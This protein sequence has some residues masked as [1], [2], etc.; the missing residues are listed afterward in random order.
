MEA[1]IK[2]CV[3]NVA[4]G[5]WYPRGQER[6][7]NSLIHHGY[8][9]KILTWCNEFPNDNYDKSSPYNVKAAAFEEAIKLGFTHI[10]WLDCSAWLLKDISPIFDILNSDGYYG[11]KSGYNCAQTCCDKC[12][13]YF[14]VLRDDAEKMLDCST[15]MFGVNITNPIG[16]EFIE[17]FI[18]ACKDGIATTS[19]F[20]DNQ[21]QD[22]R[23][24]FSR[25]EQSIASILYNT[26]GMRL[27]DPNHLSCYYAPEM[28]ESVLLTM[29]GM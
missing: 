20:H 22:S 3:I 16:K 11:W 9:G 23:F 13:D 17:R 1:H 12:L 6:L 28:P 19:R 18:Q 2:H 24:A 15:S 7:V 8:N 10:F 25:Q 29:R 5:G 14:G 21:S 27:H 4:I 26:M